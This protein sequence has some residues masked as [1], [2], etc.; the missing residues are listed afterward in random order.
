MPE[1]GTWP[2]LHSKFQWARMTPRDKVL[3]SEDSTKSSR[4]LGAGQMK[5]LGPEKLAT[6]LHTATTMEGQSWDYLQDLN[7]IPFTLN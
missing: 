5:K 6:C 7:A 4:P 1:T 3:G 2:Q